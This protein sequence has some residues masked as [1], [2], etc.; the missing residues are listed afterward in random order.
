MSDTRTRRF[1]F[2]ELVQIS[3]LHASKA[4]RGVV[5]IVTAP[6]G[7]PSRN[8]T[9]V[10]VRQLADPTQEGSGDPAAFIGIDHPAWVG[11]RDEATLRATEVAAPELAVGQVIDVPRRGLYVVTGITNGKARAH[12]LGGSDDGK[13][14]TG[15][16]AASVTVIPVAELAARLGGAK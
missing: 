8:S 14:L 11:S 6:P 15:I 3:P 5:W 4:Q 7:Y 12:K 1:S 16:I 13:Y 10:K 9:K 2:D